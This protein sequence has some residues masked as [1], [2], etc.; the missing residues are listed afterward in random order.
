[1]PILEAG[2]IVYGVCR[3]DSR[4]IFHRIV[5]AYAQNPLR[6]LRI[7]HLLRSW[8]AFHTTYVLCRETKRRICVIEYQTQ[9]W[10]F[11]KSMPTSLAYP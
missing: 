7:L 2:Y 8:D 10:N 6:E 4:N 5:Q 9:F 11:C 1:M 3:D